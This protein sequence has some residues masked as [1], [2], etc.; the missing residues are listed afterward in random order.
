[1]RSILLTIAALMK[2]LIV[3]A[4]DFGLTSG[5]VAGIVE[6]HDRGIVTATSLMVNAPAA[7]EAFAWAREHR[8]LA[9]GLH[10]VLTFGRPVGPAWPLGELVDDDG[11]FRRLESGAHGRAS[12]GQVAAEL[13]AQLERFEAQVGRPPTHIDSHHHAHR[14]PGILNA[15]IEAARRRR[16][17]VRSPDE[18]TLSRL[19]AA[20]IATSDSFIDTFYGEDDVSVDHLIAIFDDLAEGTAELMCH[21]AREDSLLD[22][23]SSY[24]RARYRE[25]ETLVSPSVQH[26]LTERDIELVSFGEGS[27]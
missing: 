7:D 16:L 23:L 20:G 6:A 18:T 8:S 11:A 10:F 17:P 12:A 25:R 15:V 1:M 5:V 2:R 13:R 26:A 14:E 4:D 27:S 22:S 3:T 24:T 19:R 9:V 21:P